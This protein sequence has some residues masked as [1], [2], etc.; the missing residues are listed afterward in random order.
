MEKLNEKSWK[1]GAGSR[2]TMALS[3]QMAR[4]GEQK[5]DTINGKTP[6]P[7]IRS[8]RTQTIEEI[9]NGTTTEFAH[10]AG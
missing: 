5:Q 4:Q 10:L 6:S 7:L 2:D 3:R 9:K 1:M 8:R